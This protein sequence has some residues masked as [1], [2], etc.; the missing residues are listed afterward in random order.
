MDISAFLPRRDLN[1]PNQHSVVLGGYVVRII[2]STAG[3]AEEAMGLNG[4][5]VGIGI[6]DATC[7]PV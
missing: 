7:D 3:L 1:H 2:S 5:T 4:F 6:V